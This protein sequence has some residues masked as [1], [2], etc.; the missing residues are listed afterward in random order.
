[1]VPGRGPARPAPCCPAR[2][3]TEGAPTMTHPD[4]PTPR[5]DSRTG[6]A[7]LP[8]VGDLV[9]PE[10]EAE[11]VWAR[12]ESWRPSVGA[13]DPL[14][15]WFFEQAVVNSVRVDRCRAHEAAVRVYQAGR[16][17]VC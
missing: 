13:A 15:A 3:T 10:G 12:L 9:L 6:A 1:M 8:G 5:D 17:E 16:A 11:A 14:G 2:P 7:H 4:A